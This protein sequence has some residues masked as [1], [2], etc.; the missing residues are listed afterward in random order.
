[1]KW[2]F[3]IEELND[4]Q[5][6]YLVDMLVGCHRYEHIMDA[7]DITSEGYKFLKY[8][9][10]TEV[11]D[12]NNVIVHSGIIYFKDMNISIE[13]LM[14]DLCAPLEEANDDHVEYVFSEIEENVEELKSCNYVYINGDIYDCELSEVTGEGITPFEHLSY[15][16]SYKDQHDFIYIFTGK[17]PDE[18]TWKDIVEAE[19]DFDNRS[20]MANDVNT[21]IWLWEHMEVG[22]PYD[23]LLDLTRYLYYRHIESE[24]H[25][26][27]MKY[28]GLYKFCKELIS[29]RVIPSLNAKM[30]KTFIIEGDNITLYDRA[31]SISCSMSELYKAFTV[32]ADERIEDSSELAD[33]ID[34][35]T[36]VGCLYQHCKISGVDMLLRP[37]RNVQCDM[38]KVPDK[39]GLGYS[40]IAQ[41]IYDG[42][43]PK[44][45]YDNPDDE[46][47]DYTV[48]YK[49]PDDIIPE[50]N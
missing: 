29:A 48:V 26:D 1:M 36:S 3:K 25:E 6:F 20:E 34:S 49:N 19:N 18:D 4:N 27:H 8:V 9:R 16:R 40:Q 21:I 7:I 41:A 50:I 22:N 31:T 46:D 13:I 38:V 37:C 15:V 12:K 5:L 14:E 23:T 44:Y 10:D 39:S 2:N 17:E 35:A 42:R 30:R 47:S 33:V 11:D 24:V 45:V 43:N 28:L 32:Y